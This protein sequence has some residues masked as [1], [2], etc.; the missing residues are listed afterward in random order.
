MHDCLI[1]EYKPGSLYVNLTNDCTNSCIFCSRT[2]GSFHLDKFNLL[3]SNEHGA[4]EYIAHLRRSIAG[5]DF[6][7]EIVFCGYGEPTLR[8][9]TLIEIATWSKGKGFPVRLNT[10]GLVEMIHDRDV[11]SELIGLIHGVNVSLNAPDPHSYAR[12]SNP[13]G[14]EG[15]WRWVLGFLRRCLKYLPETWAS[16]VGDALSPEELSATRALCSNLGVKLRVR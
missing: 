5:R 15:V 4:D 1:Y 9:D 10:N 14:G 11:V 3:L 2:Y 6:V 7:R 12:I 8:L 16:V 13:E